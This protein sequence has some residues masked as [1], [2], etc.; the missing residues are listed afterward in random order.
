MQPFGPVEPL[1]VHAVVGRGDC[2]DLVEDLL[3]VL[4]GELF[5]VAHLC[6]EFTDDLPVFL[7]FTWRVLGFAPHLNTP[8]GAG[9]GAAPFRIAGGRQDD[10]GE[11]GGLGQEDILHDQEL[12]AL[13]GL[14]D[15]VEVRVGEHRVL[16]H[17]VHALEFAGVV[18]QDVHHDG[19]LVA[20]LRLADAVREAPCIGELLVGGRV[21]DLLVTGE[22]NREGS[23][24]TGT[25][26]VVLAAEC[27]HAAAAPA[28]VSGQHLKVCGR[29]DVVNTHG[30]LG[31]SHRVEECAGFGGTDPFGCSLELLGRDAGDLRDVL[32]E[33]IIL[34]HDRF[35]F[36]VSLCTGRNPFLVL[37]SVPDDL[38][39]QAVQD[40][41][42][43]A[44]VE[45]RVEVRL[46]G[47]RRVARV[48]Y[49]E[50]P[51]VQLCLH[52]LAAD[53]RVLLEGVGPDDEDA[54]RLGDVENRVGHRTGPERCGK[55]RDGGCM[56]EPGAVVDVP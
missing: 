11:F 21:G 3:D 26:H 47:G 51:A 17:D 54:L 30:V 53:Q 38:S 31:D 14:P 1:V 12:Q 36:L 50:F 52:G 16:A 8:L 33:V 9:L 4:V 19:D 13:E 20:V 23:H 43:G 15:M 42:V 34:E 10:V 35:E 39:H 28:D 55:P 29:L 5:R 24:I 2:G 45:G 37:P 7:R 6:G 18:G 40:G 41:H 48:K 27:V 44:G 56:A 32:G 22:D 49:D 25:L 46:L